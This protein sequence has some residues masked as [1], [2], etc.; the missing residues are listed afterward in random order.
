[1]KVA[2]SSLT[3]SGV[4]FAVIRSAL[5]TRLSFVESVAF[6][7]EE[8]M[9]VLLV[10][11]DGAAHCQCAIDANSL[12]RPNVKQLHQHSRRH[13]SAAACSTFKV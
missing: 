6:F 9:N 4:M 2:R 10:L 12:R 8:H 1:L 3:E 11:L 5:M 13:M 7:A